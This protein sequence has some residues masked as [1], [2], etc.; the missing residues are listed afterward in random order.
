MITNDCTSIIL[1][2]VVLLIIIEYWLYRVIV[3]HRRR[4]IQSPEGGTWA[5]STAALKYC[6]GILA[7]DLVHFT[8][9]FT[10]FLNQ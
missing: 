4:K 5:Q 3:H 1:Y 10:L 9:L 7:K 8:P 2:A 6:M